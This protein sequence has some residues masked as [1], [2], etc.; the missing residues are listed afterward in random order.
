MGYSI[1]RRSGLRSKF[2]QDRVVSRARSGETWRSLLKHVQ[3]D[4]RVW[5]LM[6]AAQG[7]RPGSIII[8]L[9]GN[10]VYGRV[11][12]LRSF[13]DDRLRKV[14]HKARAVVA[15]VQRHTEEIVILGPLPR[16][17]AELYG[18]TWEAPASYHLD[19]TLRKSGLGGQVSIVTLGRALCRKISRKRYGIRDGCEIWFRTDGVHLSGAGYEKVAQVGGLPKLADPQS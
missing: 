2:H 3:A 9:T 17:S 11:S 15:L 6:A 14:G 1:A 10:D 12:G 16:I 7:L 8:W 4:I 13:D 5:Q 18:D 19:R